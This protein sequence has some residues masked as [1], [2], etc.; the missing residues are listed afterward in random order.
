M[1]PLQKLFYWHCGLW[2]IW[3]NN[4]YLEL[5]LFTECT[6]QFARWIVANMQFICGQAWQND[7]ATSYVLNGY[8]SCKCN[9]WGWQYTCLII[10]SEK[11]VHTVNCISPFIFNIQLDFPVN[12]VEDPN[13]TIYIYIYIY[14]SEAVSL[15]NEIMYIRI[16]SITWIKYVYS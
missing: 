11:F 9:N 3:D 13:E 7:V 12:R 5:I 10:L 15:S 4:I 2:Y 16:V 8:D 6:Q 14:T 1:L